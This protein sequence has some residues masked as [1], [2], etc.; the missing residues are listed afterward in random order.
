MTALY[1]R[2]SA[3]L[4]R[5]VAPAGLH[6]MPAD[7]L[8][9]RLRIGCDISYELP[10][11]TPMILMVTVHD[12]RQNHLEAPDR[13]TTTPAVPMQTYRD[14]FGNTRHRLVAPA[15]EFRLRIATVMRD[16]GL[17]DMPFPLAEQYAVEHLPAGVLKFLSPS[18]YCDTELLSDIAWQRFGHIPAGWAR[19]QA[20]CDFAH[21]HIR[22]DYQQARAT[23]T[24]SEAYNEQQG[25]C[26]DYAHLAISLCRAL[27]IPA[28]YCTGYVSDVGLN[29]PPSDPMDYAAWMEVYLGGRWHAFD[30]RNNAPRVGRILIGVGR[31]AADVPIV[32]SFGA[33]RLTGFKVLTEEAEEPSRGW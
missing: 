23:R 21:S 28:R 7:S 22:F 9:L 13:I 31:D 1:T 16:S 17:P 11:S 27:N 25:V 15:G 3:P 26:R 30:P 6:P 32:H 18:R 14:D 5:A 12:T 2:A 10:Q 19:V 24:A 4:L 8:P 20:I 33:N 29:P